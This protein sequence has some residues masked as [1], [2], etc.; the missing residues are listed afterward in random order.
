MKVVEESVL[1]MDKL[2]LGGAQKMWTLDAVLMSMLSWEL[3]IHD[4]SV[5]FAKKLVV[6]MT[7]MLKKRAHD[8]YP[9][10]AVKEDF[11]RTKKNH[12]WGMTEIEPF[13]PLAMRPDL[14][15]L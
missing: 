12:G 13:L 2:L 7:R 15:T 1:M 14:I 6:I 8:H 3:L 5:S 9:K 11:Y 4:M 10:S